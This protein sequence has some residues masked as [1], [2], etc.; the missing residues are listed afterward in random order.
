[1]EWTAATEVNFKH[2]EIQRSLDGIDFKTIGS[3]IS[4]GENTNVQ[5]QFRDENP[6]SVNYYR[7]KMIDIDDTYQYSKVV[8]KDLPC[9]QNDKGYWLAFPNPVRQGEELIIQSRT[10]LKQYTVSI[11]NILGEKVFENTYT[12]SQ[13]LQSLTLN[14]QGLPKGVNLLTIRDGVHVMYSSK[15]LVVGTN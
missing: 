1:M 6:A 3:R 13:E 14:T 11:T 4:R 12:A 2:Y 10:P 7:L 9:K 5:Y 8:A 15:L